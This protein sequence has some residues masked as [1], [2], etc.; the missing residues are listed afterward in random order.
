MRS[1]RMKRTQKGFVGLIVLIAALLIV[2]GL[3]V[4]NWDTIDQKIRGKRSGAQE[5]I[6]EFQDKV[7]DF[8]EKVDDAQEKLK[9]RLGE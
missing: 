9:E 7:D 2:A 4:L 3:V 1:K 5:K 6:D 8:Q